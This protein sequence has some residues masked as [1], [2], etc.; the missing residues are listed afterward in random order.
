MP[1]CVVHQPVSAFDDHGRYV[2]ESVGVATESDVTVSAAPADT[3]VVSVT[4]DD[5]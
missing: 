1:P 5:M 3:E 4:D 2:G